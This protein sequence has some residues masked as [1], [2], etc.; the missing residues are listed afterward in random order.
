[1]RSRGVMEKCTLSIQRIR[2]ATNLA[3]TE[4]RKIRD[5]EILPACVQT[6]PTRALTFGDYKQ[7]DWRM[8][9]L[10]RDP[11]AYRLLDGPLK[12]PPRRR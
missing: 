3:K 8:P 10:A 7:T 1:V 11:R 9:K 6:C 5:G 4:G 2:L 12:H